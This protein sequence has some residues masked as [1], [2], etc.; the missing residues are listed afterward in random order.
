MQV[1]GQAELQPMTV[2]IGKCQSAGNFKVRQKITRK[3]SMPLVIGLVEPSDDQLLPCN[4]IIQFFEVTLGLCQQVMS[5]IAHRRRRR[6]QQA[7]WYL[8]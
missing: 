8:E 5:D 6:S 3:I 7:S 4:P 2:P 1:G